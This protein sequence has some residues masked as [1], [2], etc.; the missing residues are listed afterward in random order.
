MALVLK[1]INKYKFIIS[2]YKCWKGV[3]SYITFIAWIKDHTDSFLGLKEIFIST[4]AASTTFN[5]IM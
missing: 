1:L 5:S 2:Q 4:A 3:T